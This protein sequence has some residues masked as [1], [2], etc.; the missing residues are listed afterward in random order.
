MGNVS[1]KVLE[2]SLN[3][4]FKKKVDYYPSLYVTEFKTVLDSKFHAVD[5]GFFVSGTWIPDCNC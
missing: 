4:L 1:L 3:F 5:S 2:K